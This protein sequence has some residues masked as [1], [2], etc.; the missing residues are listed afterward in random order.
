LDGEE[1]TLSTIRPSI[2]SEKAMKKEHFALQHARISL[3][4]FL[5]AFSVGF[6]Q[7]I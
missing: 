2:S 6:W 7:A 3:L 5:G 1:I 4:F